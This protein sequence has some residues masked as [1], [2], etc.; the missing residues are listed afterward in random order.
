MDVWCTF[1]MACCGEG[2]SPNCHDRAC[3]TFHTQLRARTAEMALC[4]YFPITVALAAQGEGEAEQQGQRNV[5]V[6]A[7]LEN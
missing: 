2:Q 4:I 3:F 5:C 7:N 6:L 1:L